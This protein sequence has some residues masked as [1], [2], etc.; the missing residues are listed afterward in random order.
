MLGWVVRIFMIVS[1]VVAGLFIAKDAPLFGMVQ[2]MVMLLLLA[3]IVAVLAFWPE[4]QVSK[5]DRAR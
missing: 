4:R 5:R 1:G 2:V 3:L